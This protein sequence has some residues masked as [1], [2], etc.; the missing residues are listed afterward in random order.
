MSGRSVVRWTGILGLAA[1]A[2]Q[3]VAVIFLFAA[4]L[5]PAFEDTAKVLAYLK[6]AHF[7]LTT[8]LILFSIGFAL[9]IGFNA[10]LRSV[11]VGATG[12]VDWVGN[13][14]FGGGGDE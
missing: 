11:G 10:G 14:P 8:A 4:G 5:P 6:G 12:D 9:L 7:A 3:L 2:A 1:I 13:A